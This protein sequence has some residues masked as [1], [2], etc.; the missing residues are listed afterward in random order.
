MF[1]IHNYKKKREYR[2]AKYLKIEIIP[3]QNRQKPLAYM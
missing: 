3:S 2:L 1:T